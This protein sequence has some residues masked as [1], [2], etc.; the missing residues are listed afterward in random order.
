MY[1]I[2]C[3][4]ISNALVL[5]EAVPMKANE[6]SGIGGEWI[7]VAPTADEKLRFFSL[8]NAISASMG[9]GYTPQTN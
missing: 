3:S 9:A 2:L 1:R 6:S 8:F 7:L 5:R 4:D